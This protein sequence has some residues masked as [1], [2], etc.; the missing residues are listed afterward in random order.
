MAFENGSKVPLIAGITETCNSLATTSLIFT[1]SSITKI[2]EPFAL[3]TR[4]IDFNALSPFVIFLVYKAAAIVTER[5]LADS[6]SNEDVA[7]L[8]LL[9]SF[10]VLVGERWLGCGELSYLFEQ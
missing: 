4:S 6:D 5:L 1:L 2:I 7:R 8:R 9:R 3:R 10:M